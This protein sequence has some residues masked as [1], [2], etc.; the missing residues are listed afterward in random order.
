MKSLFV[1]LA[2]G[3][4]VLAGYVTASDKYNTGGLHWQW[5][6]LICK[7]RDGKGVDKISEKP[8]ECRIALREV[9]F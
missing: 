6:D 8:A 2:F 4:I 3:L 9:N 7:T 5:R 1:A